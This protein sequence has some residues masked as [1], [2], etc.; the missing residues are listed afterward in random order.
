MPPRRGVKPATKVGAINYKDPATHKCT[1]VRS[2]DCMH[3]NFTVIESYFRR[4]MQRARGLLRKF[5]T[6]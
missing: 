5:A 3:G 1:V 2:Y 4:N 6:R